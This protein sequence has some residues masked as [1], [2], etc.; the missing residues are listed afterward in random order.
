MGHLIR[1]AV[2]VVLGI[3]LW[4]LWVGFKLDPIQFA[5]LERQLRGTWLWDLR[6]PAIPL[7]AVFTLW[8]AERLAALVPA[9]TP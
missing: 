2:T 3:A 7:Y 6:Y 1:L 8:V 5:G 4:Q 9:K